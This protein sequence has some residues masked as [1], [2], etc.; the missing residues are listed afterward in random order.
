MDNKIPVAL[1]LAA[2]LLGFFGVPCISYPRFHE[3]G[4]RIAPAETQDA[5]VTDFRVIGSGVG[6]G[7]EG[8]EEVGGI[9]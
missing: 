3:R 2:G 1:V 5:P 4:N 6:N 8:M 9:R 7:R